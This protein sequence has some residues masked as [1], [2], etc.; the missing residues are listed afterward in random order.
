[1]RSQAA[2][3]SRE[4]ARPCRRGRARSWSTPLTLSDRS[5]P[6]ASVHADL[7]ARPAV[8]IAWRRGGRTRLRTSRRPPRPGG[9]APGSPGSACPRRRLSAAFAG[10]VE[11]EPEEEP[12]G[13]AQRLEQL[14]VRDLVVL[15]IRRLAAGARRLRDRPRGAV[16]PR[17]AKPLSSAP[18]SPASASPAAGSAVLVGLDL[19]ARRGEILVRLP[20]EQALGPRFTKPCVRLRGRASRAASRSV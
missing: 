16:R 13:G 4:G 9:P 20:R 14:S 7:V 1:M 2:P 12:P 5:R 15:E 19:L 6:S 10:L 17:R 3:E 18:I 11:P 8:G